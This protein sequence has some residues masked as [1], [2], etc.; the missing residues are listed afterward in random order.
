MVEDDLTKTTLNLE[1]YALQHLV[2]LPARHPQYIACWTR[3]KTQW[4]ANPC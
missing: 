2:H 1:W 3:M 4:P